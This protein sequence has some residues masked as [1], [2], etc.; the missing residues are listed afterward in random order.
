MKIVCVI[1][2]FVFG[3]A[4]RVMTNLANNLSSRHSVTFI[5]LNSI[6]KPAY[7][8]S[9]RVRI[10]NGLSYSNKL[11]AIIK[12]RNM[13]LESKPDIVLSFI[14]HVNIS[15]LLALI[16]TKI[17]VVI[18]ERNDP[19]KSATALRKILRT[20]LYPRASGIVFQT[21]EAQ[22]YYSNKIQKNS[23]VIA[24]PIFV[25]EANINYRSLNR[26]NEI[27][28]VGRLEPQKNYLLM[29]QAIE[30]IHNEFP[31]IKLKIFGEGKE[32]SKLEQ[33]I[34]EHSLKDYVTLC[35]QSNNVHVEIRDS[36]LFV[37]TSN[38]EGMPNAL[39]EAMALGLCCV[40]TDCPV[41][42]PRALIS[43]NVNGLLI[44]VGDVNELVENIRYVLLNPEIANKM[45]D[46][47][48]AILDKLNPDY[49]YKQ[50]ENYLFNCY[51][52]KTKCF[53]INIV[54]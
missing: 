45:G 35:G 13:I 53:N 20:I 33:Y 50:W 36:R 38:H 25:S 7:E 46:N 34:I 29:L 5:A 6:S 24:N 43:N 40:C 44:K 41:G 9:E 4:E 16:G 48:R 54:E 17:P 1:G 10:I 21:E 47:A 52:A 37:M 22:K 12:L 26:N 32:R 39:M 49:V 30:K 15:V 23:K 3:G 28:C 19:S 18:S 42:G 14:T 51:A 8:I 2:G 11:D 27:V 31:E